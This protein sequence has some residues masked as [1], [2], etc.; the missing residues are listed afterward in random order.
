[1]LHRPD[2]TFLTSIISPIHDNRFIKKQTKHKP[3]RDGIG[4]YDCMSVVKDREPS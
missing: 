1:M 2:W 4:H 3:F